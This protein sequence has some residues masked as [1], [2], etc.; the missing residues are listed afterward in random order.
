MAK[1]QGEK[2]IC[3]ICGK[4]FIFSKGEQEFFA[5]KGLK[6]I[7]KSCPECREIRRQGEEPMLE[8]KCDKCGKTGVFRK[9][10]EAKRILCADCYAKEKSAE[11]PAGNQ[12]DPSQ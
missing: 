4:E 12:A 1:E 6:N 2:L 9:K 11:N 3:K 10:I 5:E 8:V 7:P